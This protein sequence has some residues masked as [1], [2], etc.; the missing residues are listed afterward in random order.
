M[1][2]E[3][4]VPTAVIVCFFLIL[5]AV[6]NVAP[7][8]R[9]QRP[10]GQRL[11]VNTVVGALAL[12]AGFAIVAPSAS[13]TLREVSALRFGLLRWLE[14]PS[15]VELVLGVALLD[16]SFYYW[17]RANHTVPFLWRFHNA[18]HVDPDLDV[19]TAYRFHFAE[20]AMSA[21]FRVAQI[22]VIGVSPLTFAIYEVMFHANTIFQ[23]SNLRLPIGVERVLNAILVTPRMHG[24]HH[25]EIRE[26]NNSNYSVVFPWWDR[27]HRTLRLNLPQDDVIIGI[28]AY[29]D[30]SDNKAAS[31][32]LMPFR[33]QRDYW[34]RADGSSAR[35]REPPAS[36]PAALLAA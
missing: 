30:E 34:R 29:R 19:T 15:T 12:A 25:S 36:S 13:T 22:A 32:L 21:A 26:E 33:S 14:T 20:V 24:I 16:L 27:L 11:A 2:A 28:A 31:V 1:S 6:E 5:L 23:H 8:R 17:H 35:T 7:L 9:R 4:L 10:R 18:H 3:K